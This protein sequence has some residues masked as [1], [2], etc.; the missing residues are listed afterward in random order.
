MAKSEKAAKG[1]PDRASSVAV[2]T[3]RAHCWAHGQRRKQVRIAGQHNHELANRKL[4]DAGQPLPWE[5]AQAERAARRRMT[6]GA[7][8][9]PFENGADTCPLCG[10]TLN[11]KA[12]WEKRQ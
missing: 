11:L 8:R 5:Q 6:C 1:L 12:A 9:I 2:K 4:R 7:C 3:R 10:G